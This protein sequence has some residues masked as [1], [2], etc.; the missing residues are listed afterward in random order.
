MRKRTW[1]LKERFHGGREIRTHDQRPIHIYS[2]LPSTPFVKVLVRRAKGKRLTNRLPNLRLITGRDKNKKPRPWEKRYPLVH[3]RR[4]SQN[5]VMRFVFGWVA[6]EQL[7]TT[8]TAGIK[9]M[10]DSGGNI[11]E[12]ARYKVGG[13]RTHQ[14]VRTLETEASACH[15][16]RH[17]TKALVRR[18]C[19]FVW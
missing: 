18:A 17:R 8:T 6:M 1:S 10:F 16:S 15:S 5:A 4:M 2:V 14:I 7:E 13:E 9:N 11:M 3:S 12:H 19:I